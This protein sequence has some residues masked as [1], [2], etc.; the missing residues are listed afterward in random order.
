MNTEE[1][2]A[3]VRKIISAVLCMD[4]SEIEDGELLSTYGLTSID[5]LDILVKV[6]QKFQVGFDPE[7]MHELSCRR[8][9]E[10]IEEGLAKRC[11]AG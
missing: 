7:R 6:E 4:E 10:N 9:T 2:R 8:L 5:L 3:D 1:V 11:A